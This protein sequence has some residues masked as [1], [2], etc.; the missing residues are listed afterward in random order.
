LEQAIEFGQGSSPEA[1]RVRQEVVAGEGLTALA[2]AMFPGTANAA[3]R[4]TFLAT[5][6]AYDAWVYADTGTDPHAADFYPV[7]EGKTLAQAGGVRFDELGEEGVYFFAV[8]WYP[9]G[10]DT[11]GGVRTNYNAQVLDTTGDPIH[12]VFAVGGVSNRF[13]FGETYVGGSS[14][15]F[16]PAIAR[17]AAAKIMYVLGHDEEMDWSFE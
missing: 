8:R 10:W 16:Y 12:N 15:T 5:M 1:L 17:R 6:A 2:N 11:A 13:Y 9:T 3:V 14:L 4:T 7:G